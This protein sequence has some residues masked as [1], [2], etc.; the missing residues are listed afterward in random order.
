VRKQTLRREMILKHLPILLT[1]LVLGVANTHAWAA[2]P[3]RLI[4]NIRLTG[5]QGRIDHM[6]IDLKGQRL[7]VVALGN[8]TLEILDLRAGQPANRIGG[9]REPQGVLYLPEFNKILVANGGDGSC[10]IF[11]ATSLRPTNTLKFSHDADNVRY[12]PR[13]KQIYVGYGNGALGI[14]KAVSWKQIGDVRLAGHP[15]SFQLE[16]VGPRIFVNVPTANQVSVVDRDRHV[17]IDTWT[18]E[19]ARANFPM[20]LDEMNHRLLIGC[21]R[22]P[23]ILVYDTESGRKITRLDI[24]GDVDDIFYD[25]INRRIYASC[26]EGFLN[27]FRKNEADR[28]ATLA[29]IPTETGA[30]TSLY[31]PEQ[32]RLYLAVPATREQ[33]AHIHVYVVEQ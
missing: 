9:F 17:V 11:D 18:L 7:F 12:D 29:N 26:G 22:P 5:V 27:V 28:Y 31:V 15:E 23:K 20:A 8:N 19:G 4:Q 13:T 1:A 25:S 21:R 2:A 24:A 14:I 10:N 6:A 3:L 32:G 33:E 16:A 30:R